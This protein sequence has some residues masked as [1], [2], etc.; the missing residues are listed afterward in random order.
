[1]QLVLWH[2]MRLLKMMQRLKLQ[3]AQSQFFSLQQ[4][5]TREKTENTQ[6]KAKIKDGNHNAAQILLRQ[7]TQPAS[8][9][10]F[11]LHVCVYCYRWTSD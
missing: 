9:G 8:S 10:S 11:E 6:L 7:L 2:C 4:A 3:E 5:Y 1:M